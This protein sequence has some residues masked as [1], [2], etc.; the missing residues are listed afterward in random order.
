MGVAHLEWRLWSI[1]ANAGTQGDLGSTVVEAG[2]RGP[3]EPEGLVE[4]RKVSHVAGEEAELIEATGTVETQRQPQNVRWTTVV[5]PRD[6][7]TPRNA[8]KLHI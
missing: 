4:N 2:E 8:T 7:Q 6:P 5:T 1:K 3:G